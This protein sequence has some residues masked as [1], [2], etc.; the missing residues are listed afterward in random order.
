MSL[1]MDSKSELGLDAMS[2]KKKRVF[3]CGLPNQI[4]ETEI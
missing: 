1:W 2:Q 4:L 3:E